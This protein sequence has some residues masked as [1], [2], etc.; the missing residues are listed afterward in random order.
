MKSQAQKAIVIGIDGASMELILNQVQW[1]NMP[2]VKRLLAH[3]VYRPMLGTYPTLTPPGWT[4][5]YTGAWHGTHEVMDFNIRARGK[6]LDET[7]WGIDTRLSKAEYLWNTAERAGKKP[8]L[9]KVEMSWPPTIINGVQVEGTGPGVSN[10]HQI[11]GYH[12]FVAGNWTAR[13]IGGARDSEAV[14]PS[15]LQEGTPYDPVSLNP[16]DTTLWRNLPDSHKPILEAELTIRPLARGRDIMLRGKSGIPKT[17]YALIYAPGAEGYRN[18][19]I[20]RTQDGRDMVAELSAGQWS[21]WWLESFEIDGTAVEGNVRMKLITLSENADRLELFMPQIWPVKGYTYPETIA[22]ELNEHVGP[23]LQNPGRDALGLIDDETFFELLEYHHQHL[24]QVAHYLASSRPWDILFVE[25][26]ASD[27]CDHF[28]IG[29]SDPISGADPETIKR[30]RNGLDKT[31][32]SIDRWIGRI[33][34]LADEDT[35]VVIASD[36]GGTPSQFRQMDVNKVLEA[37]GFLYRKNGNIDW[38]KTRAARV[39]TIHIFINLKGR[40]P[41]GIVDPE[42]YEKTQ[43]EIIDALMTY[44]DPETGRRPF[45][46]ALTR[47]DAEVIN[48][49]GELVGDVVYAFDPGFDGAHGRHLPVGRFGL[50]GQHSVFIMSGP[51]V[52]KETALQRQVRVIDVAP[53]LCYLLGWPMPRDVEGGI[54]YEALEDPDWHLTALKSSRS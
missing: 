10:H 5:L 51:G 3:G 4:A 34:E 23:F 14:D 7:I 17:L 44:R 15:A 2:N 24:A 32:A 46:L 43:R 1:G 21:R 37:T 6:P 39:G 33:L 38:S 8:I 47:E 35:V 25:T 45:K 52:R 49:W 29:Q 26:H 13:P 19:R 20:C 11:C 22:D 18:V 31:Y 53:T 30:C 9:V 36:H 12:L 41:T 16:V 54:I 28:F 40:E 48:L 42:D 27:Y 50:S